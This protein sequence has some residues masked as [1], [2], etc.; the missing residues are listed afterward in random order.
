[1]LQLSH[2]EGV[3]I[4]LGAWEVTEESVIE[5]LEAVDDALPVYLAQGLTPAVALA[6]RALGSLLQHL[7]LPPGT[8]HSLQDI[9]TLGPVPF[10]TKISARAHVERPKR[11]GPLELTTAHFTLDSGEDR[12]VV[13]GKC[14]VLVTDQQSTNSPPTGRIA[15]SPKFVAESGAKDQLPTVVKTI[16]REQLDA[17]S[18]VSGDRNPLHSD[19]Q[20]AATTQFGGIIA[21]GML[22]LAFVSQMM[23]KAYGRSWLETG[24]LK[25]K[26]KGAAYLEDQVE[27][28]GQVT[29]EE[30]ST[31]GRRLTCAVA[32]FDRQRS[33][34]LVTGTATLTTQ[35]T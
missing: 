32:V 17:Y 16:T 1:M 9:E 5:Y 3:Q 31:D 27:T 24:T 20:F 35:D 18:R 13:K 4:D 23:T 15:A 10:G 2:N 19:A 6:A 7:A 25:V 34:E 33:R 11:R 29:K 21:H 22:T 30:R 8:I 12:Q 14:T 26:F 28:S